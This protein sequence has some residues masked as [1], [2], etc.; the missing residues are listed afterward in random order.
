MNRVDCWKSLRDATI[1][2]CVLRDLK[3]RPQTLHA[4]AENCNLTT[5]SLLNPSAVRQFNPPSRLSLFM[6]Y[7]GKHGS[8]LAHDLVEGGLALRLFVDF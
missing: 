1:E 8:R 4:T 2:I 3:Y 6:P 5:N 7:V